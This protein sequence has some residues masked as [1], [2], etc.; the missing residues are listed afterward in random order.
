MSE[1][2]RTGAALNKAT[3]PFLVEDESKTWRL[4]ATTL[5]VIAGLSALTLFTPYWPLQIASG[6]ATGLVLVR[7]FI[8]FHDYMHGAILQK[9][10]LMSAIMSVVG[11]VFLTVKSV[12]K[13]THDYHHKHNSKLIGSSIGSYPLLTIGMYNRL[14]KSKRFLYRFARHPLT[15]FFGYLPVFMI[16]MTISPFMRD[17]KRHWAGPIALILHWVA[18]VAAVSAFGWVQGLSLTMLP[19]AV[20]TGVGS[21]LFY[22]QHNFPEMEL[23]GRRDW[24]YTH[25]ALHASSMFEMG[26]LGHWLTGNIGYHH[27]H[28]L[29]HRI[30]FYRLPE[31]MEAI[32]ELQN[33][34][35]TSWKPKDVLGCLN[36]GLWCTE[37]ER[38]VSFKDAAS[39]A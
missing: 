21:Y 26:P 3:R 18:V 8:F 7:L 34:G 37:Q 20:V 9:S 33:P 4:L 35:I 28:H 19:V 12:W 13:E 30:P 10:K 36:L 1:T 15:I 32:P 27:V 14:P 17:P 38:M 31:A 5:A 6:V 11:F 2:A 25:A 39:R 24:D 22:A 29:N 23:R 16:G